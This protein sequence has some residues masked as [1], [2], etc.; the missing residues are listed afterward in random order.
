MGITGAVAIAAIITARD[1][2]RRVEVLPV[3]GATSYELNVL[4]DGRSLGSAEVARRYGIQFRGR[5]LLTAEGLRSIV[6]TRETA[7]DGTTA[8]V[9]L[10]VHLGAGEEEVWLWPES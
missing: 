8:F 7:A 4:V 5:T 9:R 2:S 6:R 3:H 1:P 10:H